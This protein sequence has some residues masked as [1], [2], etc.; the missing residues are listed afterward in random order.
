M[1]KTPPIRPADATPDSNEP[2]CSNCGYTL[3]D[4]TDSARCPECGRP[5]V[6]VLTRA[7]RMAEAGR[8]YRSES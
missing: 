2:Y 3:T 6:E 4:L 1:P 7:P 5:F 8:R